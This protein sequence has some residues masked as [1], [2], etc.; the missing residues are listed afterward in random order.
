MILGVLGELPDD[1]ATTAAWLGGD[2]W[3]GWTRGVGV[4]ADLF[5]AINVNTRA[6]GQWRKKPPKID[7][8]PRPELSSEAK[9]HT[10]K[11]KRQSVAD[12]RRALGIPKSPPPARGA[13]TEQ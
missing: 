13:A 10:R 2:D 4:L 6:T 12:V 1:A 3:R 9:K 7:A 5:D 8:Y 11:K